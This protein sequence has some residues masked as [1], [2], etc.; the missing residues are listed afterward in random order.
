[1][2]F[3]VKLLLKTLLPAPLVPIS[4]RQTH[5][6]FFQQQIFCRSFPNACS[7]LCFRRYLTTLMFTLSN[8]YISHNNLTTF[9]FAKL[10]F[11]LKLDKAKLSGVGL[12][13]PWEVEKSV[14]MTHKLFFSLILYL[15][16]LQYRVLGG[17]NRLF[18]LSAHWSSFADKNKSHV[19]IVLPYVP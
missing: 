19:F 14:A 13:W 12:R 10:P 18:H 17:E 1:M 8:W 11:L 15:Y 6:L 7:N 3:V 4:H 16:I 2:C 5:F 9:V